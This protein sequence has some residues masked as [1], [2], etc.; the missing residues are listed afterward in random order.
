MEHNASHSDPLIATFALDPSMTSQPLQQGCCRPGRICRRTRAGT[1]TVEF[2]I[3][4]PIFLIFLFGL[5]DIGRGFMV[6]HL[7]TDA[8]RAGCRQAV[9]PSKSNSDVKATVNDLLSKENFGSLT[10][11]I[12]VNGAEADVSTAKS[13]DEITVVLSASTDTITWLPVHRFLK[14]SITGQ[15]SLIRE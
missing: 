5:I 9:L 7:L 8:A 12:K 11:T 1:T 13:G 3:I 10:P 4:F 15:F 14:G 2:A 6:S